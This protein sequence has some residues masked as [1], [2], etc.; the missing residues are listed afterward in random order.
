MV[1]NRV[2][3]DNRKITSLITSKLYSKDKITTSLELLGLSNKEAAVYQAL[4]QMKKGTALSIA[5]AAEI[6]RPTAYQVLDTL[7][8]K[9]LIATTM[10]RGVRD[11]R[12]L[13][14]EHLSR[15]IK[16][17]EQLVKGALPEMQAL[18]DKRE[19]KL[20]LRVY[21]TL[22]AVKVL[23]EKSLREKSAVCFLGSKER[24][25]EQL[26]DYWQFYLKRSA[27]LGISPTW[28][29]GEGEMLLMLWSDKVAFVSLSENTQVFGFK[30]SALH[31][32]YYELWNKY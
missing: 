25:V 11:Y 18:Y 30:N 31:Q 2:F 13:P 23:L 17:Q 20:R 28:K 10:Y 4:T 9:N 19:S 24:M 16:K 8:Q 32:L 1:E 22:A 7:V 27:Q 14:V 21:S 12:L 6:K 5:A 15:Y 29:S 3:M 26:G